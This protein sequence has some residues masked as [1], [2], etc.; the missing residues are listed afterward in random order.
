M[1]PGSR[2]RPPGE[3]GVPGQGACSCGEDA[4]GPVALPDTLVGTDS[5][6][7]MINGLGVVGWGVGG[8]EAEAV[9]LGQPLY[10]LAARGGRLRADRPAA[11]GRHGHRPGADRHADPAQARAWS[12]SSSSSSGRACRRMTLADRATIANMAPEYGATMGFFPVDDADARLPARAPAAPTP[13]SSWSSA[14]RKEQQLFRTDDAPRAEVTPRSLSLDLGTVEPSLAGPEAAAGP[15][16]AGGDEAVVPPVAARRRSTERGFAPATKR[17]AAHG[18]RS[19]TTATRPTIGHGAVVIA[20]I[21]SCTNTSNP[22]RDARRRPAGQ[23][24]GRAGA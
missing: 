1:P 20:A 19:Q 4:A 8:I 9:M 13:R 21:T 24:G 23:E 10:M 17:L 16:A 12:A 15:R 3:S 14:T 5:H 22:S 2:H 18:R 7:T 11:A 6:T